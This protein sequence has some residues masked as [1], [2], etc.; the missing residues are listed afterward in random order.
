MHLIIFCGLRTVRSA[1]SVYLHCLCLILLAGTEIVFQWP[2]SMRS[3]GDTSFTTPRRGLSQTRRSTWYIHP[4]RRRPSPL[5]VKGLPLDGGGTFFF[6]RG[7][8][9]IGVCSRLPLRPMDA[10]LLPGSR[11][12]LET[13]VD[14]PNL[15]QKP[16]LG[17]VRALLPFHCIYRWFDFIFLKFLPVLLCSFNL[18]KPKKISPF[19][20]FR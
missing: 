1:L 8:E 12:L 9:D 15:G 13:A 19:F 6:V 5:G 16:K 17:G 7:S 3:P 14:E 10:A 11:R 4:F 20:C 18:Q 2:S